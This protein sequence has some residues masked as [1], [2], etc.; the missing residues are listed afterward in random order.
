MF[1]WFVDRFSG[2]DGY[3]PIASIALISIS[4]DVVKEFTNVH[5]QCDEPYS[6]SFELSQPVLKVKA[7]MKLTSHQYRSQ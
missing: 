6:K 1:S 2:V 3:S 5:I 7:F 4:G